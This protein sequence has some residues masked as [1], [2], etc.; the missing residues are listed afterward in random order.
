MT[1]ILIAYNSYYADHAHNLYE[2]CADKA[3]QIAYD[4]QKSFT[5]LTTPDFTTDHVMTNIADHHVCVIAA[6]GDADGIYNEN[7]DDVI[8]IHTTNYNCAGKGIYS[9]SC[10]SAVNLCKHL[11][12]IGAKFFIGYNRPF[13]FSGA[14]P[15]AEIAMSGLNT[16]LNGNDLE[17]VRQE[18]LNKY[19]AMI[20]ES[21]PHSVVKLFLVHNKESLVFAGDSHC[22]YEDLT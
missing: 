22:R 17:S 1:D 6:H 19:D 20:A 18:M 21:D 13:R 15:Y 3:R 5:L 10:S 12:Q 7:G 9:I 8:S 2:S 11:I 4:H 14:E 16:L